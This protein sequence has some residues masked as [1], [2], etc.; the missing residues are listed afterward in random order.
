MRQTGSR[1]GGLLRPHRRSAFLGL[2]GV[3]GWLWV[4]VVDAD[5]AAAAPL[6]AFHEIEQAADRKD[7]FFRYLAP[8]IRDENVRIL[9]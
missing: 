1:F 8:L 3:V 4:P 9:A 2:F 6:P 7:E 5:V